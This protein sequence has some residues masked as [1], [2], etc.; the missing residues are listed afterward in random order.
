[1]TPAELERELAAGKVR[2]AYLLAGSEALLRDDASRAIAEAVLA[3]GPR[4]FNLDRIDGAACTEV[5]LLDAEASE[6]VQTTEL[7]QKLREQLL[8]IRD[9]YHA[10]ISLLAE[11]Q[12]GE[13]PAGAGDVLIKRTRK[14]AQILTDY[15]SNHQTAYSD[16]SNRF[17]TMTLSKKLAT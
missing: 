10:L 3:D 12:Q 2:P 13:G 1:M 14:L 6:L 7:A 11:L 9:Q 16:P 8:D 5:E 17:H 15:G 4:D